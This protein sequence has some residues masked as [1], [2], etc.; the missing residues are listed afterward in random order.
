L[1]LTSAVALFV[2]GAAMV[3]LPFWRVQEEE[4]LQRQEQ[5]RQPAT[6]TLKG[7]VSGPGGRDVRLLLV[8]KPDY[9]QLYRGE[10]VWVVPLIAK[11]VSYSNFYVDSD[12]DTI[13]HQE[14]FSVN[15]AAPGS[16]PQQIVLPELKLQTESSPT[17]QIAATKEVSDEE[18]KKLGIR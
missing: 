15:D 16:A 10:I 18:L 1:N 17:T 5:A 4:A 7:K 6:V 8:V 13:L 3:A 9:D 2:L 11:R 14:P 12:T